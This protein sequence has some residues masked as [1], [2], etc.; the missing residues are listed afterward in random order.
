MSVSSM[1]CVSPLSLGS[2]SFHGHHAARVLSGGSKAGSTADYD[3]A[4][5]RL[6]ARLRQ[7][8]DG[9]VENFANRSGYMIEVS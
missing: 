2:F 6:N 4:A 7:L 5:R 9:P 1:P 8:A 3:A